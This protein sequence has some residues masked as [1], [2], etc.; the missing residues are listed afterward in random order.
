MQA[1]ITDA[2]IYQDCY[3]A[4][5]SSSTSLEMAFSLVHSEI[6]HTQVRSTLHF[7]F[8]KAARSLKLLVLLYMHPTTAFCKASTLSLSCMWLSGQIF[9]GCCLF[10]KHMVHS[11]A[12]ELTYPSEDWWRAS[13]IDQPG[14][15]EMRRRSLPP[16]SAPWLA[17]ARARQTWSSHSTWGWSLQGKQK[18][19]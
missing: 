5:E 10:T 7:I 11:H 14:R 18:T 9:C 2:I 12:S 3:P 4:S 6:M 8:C 15:S 16:R 17:Q 13:S 1:K 19:I